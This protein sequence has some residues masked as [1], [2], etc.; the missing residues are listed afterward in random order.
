M[1]VS[2]V[3]STRGLGGAVRVSSIFAAVGKQAM[4]DDPG[5]VWE[6]GTGA[7]Q[8]V[9]GHDCGNRTSV[10][11]ITNTLLGSGVKQLA[12]VRAPF[13]AMVVERAPVDSA[14]RTCLAQRT[15]QQR[16]HEQME[17]VVGVR[18]GI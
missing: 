11:I 13:T 5:G 16:A 12:E 9:N 4:V 17:V 3:P 2:L 10:A 15:W 6:T 7:P 8:T 18:A 14:V 1:A